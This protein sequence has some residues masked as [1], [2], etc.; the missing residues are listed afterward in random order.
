MA[1][2]IVFGYAALI[3]LGY[4]LYGYV[5]ALVKH[6]FSIVDVAYGLGFVV[7]AWAALILTNTFYISQLI[8]LF[9]VSIWGARLSWHIYRRNKKKGK[10]D[11]RYTEMRNRWGK[12]ANIQ[13]LFKIFI[14]QGIVIYIV[15]IAVL[16]AIINTTS[17]E[18]NALTVIGLLAWIIGFYFES[19]GDAQLKTFI[20]KPENAGKIMTEGLWAYTRHPN[21][22]GEATMWW[23]LFIIALSVDPLLGLVTVIS[24]LWIT[25]F[26]LK[27]SGV[28]ILEKHYEGNADFEAYKKRTSVFIPWFPKK[29]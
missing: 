25:V 1:S 4:M 26:L 21:Y 15:D 18:I 29:A 5:L 6:D 10:E 7:T 16:F 14:F 20:S 27:V 2:S 3:L 24:P 19:V 22:F 12:T 8:P 28:P 23:G 9:L 17:N 13:A 11:F